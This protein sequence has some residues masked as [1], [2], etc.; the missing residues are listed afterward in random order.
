MV[1]DL[2][3]FEFRQI[4]A[5]EAVATRSSANLQGIFEPVEGIV[6]PRRLEAKGG[7]GELRKIDGNG[8]IKD[9]NWSS[10]NTGINIFSKTCS[11]KAIQAAATWLTRTTKKESD[12]RQRKPKN[13]CRHTGRNHNRGIN[14]LEEHQLPGACASGARKRSWLGIPKKEG[15]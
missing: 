2:P 3:R 11:T 14:H 7:N 13:A 10:T 5:A 15:S 9:E 12:Q 4:S 1:E 8:K 6:L